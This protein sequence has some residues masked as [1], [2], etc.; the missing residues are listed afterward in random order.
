MYAT[1]HSSEPSP[2]LF[3]LR[4]SSRIAK[5]LTTQHWHLHLPPGVQICPRAHIAVAM[6]PVTELNLAMTGDEPPNQPFLRTS[7]LTTSER[8]LAFARERQSW[9][10][11]SVFVQIA[12]SAVPTGANMKGSHTIFSRKDDAP[13]KL[14]AYHGAAGISS[15][16]IFGTTHHA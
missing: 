13:P 5:A 14:A 1:S 6:M 7:T 15:A 4:T 12:R 11:N 16:T 8:T 10:N 9:K 2:D 3:R